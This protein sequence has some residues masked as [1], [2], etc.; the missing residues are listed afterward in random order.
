MYQE[1]GVNPV[2]KGPFRENND[3]YSVVW[4]FSTFPLYISEISIIVYE[5][6]KIKII[7]IILN[8]V[9]TGL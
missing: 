9:F 3:P 6:I 8:F 4:L 7:I 1:F 2:A 5:I